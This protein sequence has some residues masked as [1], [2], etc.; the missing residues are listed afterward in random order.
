MARSVLALLLVA[1][2]AVGAG[3]YDFLYTGDTP[4]AGEAG[5]FGVTL[6]FL[7]LMADEYY[8]SDGEAEDFDADWSAIWIPVV[9]H[10]AAMDNLAFGV[11]ARF[12]MPDVDVKGSDEAY[13][14]S[15]LGD[16]WLWAKYA[17]LPDPMLTARVGFMIPTGIEPVHPPLLGSG[18]YGWDEDLDIATGK[19]EMAIDGAVMLG[20]PAGPG[21]F[22]AAVG[23]RYN[24]AREITMELRQETTF[25]Y[26]CGNEIHFAAA[27]TYFI[28]D[29]M[30]FTIAADGFFGADNEVTEDGETETDDD[31][32]AN[33]VWLN[34]SFEYMMDSGLTIGVDAQWMLMG[35]NVLA[36]KGLG[37]YLGWGA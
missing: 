33:A 28:A 22:N 26:K 35:Q 25:D 23:Y 27:Y 4:M 30:N 20:V 11:N 5:G 2:F 15:G 14:G 19:G 29:A 12:G 21:E 3:A 13:E 24:M 10:Y 36:E 1:V 8:D 34:P 17:F 9:V 32:A 37:L 16:T 18:F 7:Y 6:G 31:T